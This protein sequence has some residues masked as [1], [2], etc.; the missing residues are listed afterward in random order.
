MSTIKWLQ[1]QILQ[2]GQTG[3]GLRRGEQIWKGPVRAVSAACDSRSWR[4]GGEQ[5]KQ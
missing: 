3:L 2:K 5:V 4:M 1:Y